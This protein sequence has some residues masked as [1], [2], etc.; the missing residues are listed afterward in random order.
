MECCIDPGLNYAELPHRDSSK[1]PKQQIRFAVSRLQLSWR[2]MK[3][4]GND[5]QS[6]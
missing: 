3:V 5:R 4:I 1:I 2:L 6:V